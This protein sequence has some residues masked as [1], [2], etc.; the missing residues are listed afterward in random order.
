MA[1]KFI[2]EIS[3]NHNQD[4]NRTI[5]LIQEAKK[6]GCWGVKFQLFSVEH[7]YAPEFT[8][9][10]EKMKQWELPI[11][12]LIHIEYECEKQGL[13]FI[14]TPFDLDSVEILEGYFVDFLKIGSY[15]LNWFPLVKAI[16]ETKKPWIFSTG[17]TE[18]PIIWPINMGMDKKNPPFAILHCNS[19]YPAKPE[20]CNLSRI[21]E[22]QKI[23]TFKKYPTKVGWSDHTRNPELVLTALAQGA[24][25]VEFHFDL[26][27]GKGFEFSAGHCWKPSEAMQL[28]NRAKAN[29]QW[30]WN[31]WI[32]KKEWIYSETNEQEASK[33][34][35]D[36]EDGL[37]PLKRYRKE[38]LENV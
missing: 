17:M 13:K 18:T 4:I 12:F 3:S 9:Q 19:N 33:W 2:A 23:I 15:E 24:E 28:I 38:L 32:G 14:C 16:I 10:I 11:D 26:E 25:I 21:Q 37:R 35:T 7:L 8:K 31:K 22:I 36:P 29:A 34:H 5:Q 27:D 20:H 6:I 1:S 30:G